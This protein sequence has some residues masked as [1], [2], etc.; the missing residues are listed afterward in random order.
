MAYSG[1][2]RRIHK[3]YATRNTHYHIRRDRCVAVQEANTGRW[4]DRHAALDKK[5][6]CVLR[7]KEG[8]QGEVA[9][10]DPVSGDLLCFEGT[11]ITTAVTEIDRPPKDIVQSYRI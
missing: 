10:R 2:E 1:P 4:L 8:N 9:R 11:V 3:I 5:L 7:P 6:M